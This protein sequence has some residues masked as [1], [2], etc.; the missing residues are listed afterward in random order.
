MTVDTETK[1]AEA[2]PTV[3]KRGDSTTRKPREKASPDAPMGWDAFDKLKPKTADYAEKMAPDTDESVFKFVEERFAT[4]YRLHWIE[5][6]GKRSWICL[7][8]YA[9]PEADCPLCEIGDVP[10]VNVVYNVI[11]FANPEKPENKIWVVTSKK[12]QEQIKNYAEQTKTSP[13]NR[14]NLYWKVSRVGE[15]TQ[16]TYPLAPVKERDLVDP[17]DWGWEQSWILNDTQLAEFNDQAFTLEEIVKLNTAEELEEIA[18]EK[19]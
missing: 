5:R 19:S 12:L 15:G 10:R 2:T 1:D 11:D 13:L 14:A 8:T 6:K 3:R 16:T 9:N 7:K 4:V 17:D 18:A